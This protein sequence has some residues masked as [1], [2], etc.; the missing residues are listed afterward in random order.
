MFP[1]KPPTGGVYPYY[2]SCH[3]RNYT[4]QWFCY[5]KSQHEKTSNTFVTA[6]WDNEE[7]WLTTIPFADDLQNYK[8]CKTPAGYYIDYVSC[9]YMPTRD[10][11]WEYYDAL[12]FLTV[13]CT[14]GYIMTGIAKKPNPRTS[15][16][17]TPFA[18]GWPAYD[19]RSGN[20]LD[21][22][23]YLTGRHYRC[24]PRRKRAPL[25]MILLGCF[26]SDAY[27]QRF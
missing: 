10:Q 23:V 24:Y 16:V 17:T 9:Y 5:D 2:P 14:T 21:K 1:Q 8:C 22:I 7:N 15:G 26:P 27:F 3:V 4:N 12:Q 25:E 13:F 11:Y 20:M 19:K 6:F 18:P